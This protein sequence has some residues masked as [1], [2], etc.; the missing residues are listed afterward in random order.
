MAS[1]DLVLAIDVGAWSIKVGEFEDAADGLVM[2][3]FGYSEYST[4]MS[5]ENRGALITEAL[6]KILEEK[7]FSAKKVHI[8]LSA[9]LAFTRFVKLPPIDE[10]EGRVRQIV[11]FEAKQHVP[12]DMD[13]VI[14][15][16]QLIGSGSELDVMF[17]VIKNEIVNQITAAIEGFGLKVSLVDIATSSCYN[18]ARGNRIGDDA[19]SM[20]LSIG[21]RC[22]N[23][24]F[25]DGNQFF[26]R[27]IPIA[28]YAISQQI[29]KEF[30]IGVDEAEELKQ[31]HGFVALGGAYE[32]PESE[33]AATIS[34]IVRNV[35]TRLHGEINRSINIYRSQQKG[36]KPT[37]LYLAGGS[38]IMAYTESFFENKL[39]L[40]VEYLNAFQGIRLGDQVDRQELAERA[41]QFSEVIGIALRV[42][43]CPV[44]ISLISDKDKEKESFRGKKPYYYFSALVA[45]LIPLVFLAASQKQGREYTKEIDEKKG[46]IERMTRHLTRI[47]KAKKAK[48][49]LQQQ[50]NHIKDLEGAR[51]QH[52]EILSAIEK[53]APKGL[54]ITKIEP[55][56]GPMEAHVA[57]EASEEEEV[58][59]SG[60]RRRRG[61][62]RREGQLP[63][64][65]G[66]RATMTTAGSDA[67]I[68]EISGFY[69]TGFYFSER[70]T[71]D[72]DDVIGDYVRDLKK[73][74]KE[75]LF[76]KK[77]TTNLEN[78]RSESLDNL[79]NVV[80][81]LALVKPAGKKQ[82]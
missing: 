5:D 55:I 6:Q 13:E 52:V 50:I 70:P 49:K 80:I 25:V 27:N 8:S 15:D 68:Q 1:N 79:S 2:K 57:N 72:V 14:W 40:D 18:A 53:Y 60:G 3:Q 81:R 34:K 29:A 32:E 39:R 54:W 23:L 46:I 58:A 66:R 78:P 21:S 67:E 65:G 62:G 11:E 74:N 75:T 17:V 51:A 7:Q 24:I 31:R 82:K 77:Y 12:F 28:G 10:D 35:M 37:K 71:E 45:I 56:R 20:I 9:Q 16:Y 63:T 26:S 38:S 4:T 43:V 33:V 64:R 73:H 69:V 30:G 36:N 22:S 19:C 42:S 61:S 48:E 41:H 47:E 76:M 59:E 44:E